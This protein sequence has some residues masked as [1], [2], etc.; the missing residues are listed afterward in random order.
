MS[1][2]SAL[3]RRSGH[4]LRREVVGGDVAT[5]IEVNRILGCAPEN[6]FPFLK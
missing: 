4:S 1:E 5:A 6:W 3:G 2:W